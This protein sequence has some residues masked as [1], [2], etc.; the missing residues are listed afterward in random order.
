MKAHVFTKPLTKVVLCFNPKPRHLEHE[1]KKILFQEIRDCICSQGIPLSFSTSIQTKRVSIPNSPFIFE[2]AQDELPKKLEAGNLT[3]LKFQRKTRIYS[4]KTLNLRS[5]WNLSCCFRVC[6]MPGLWNGC[7]VAEIP[8]LHI[9][10]YVLCYRITFLSTARDGFRC[11]AEFGLHIK[12][13][14]INPLSLIGKPEL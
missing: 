11:F 13:K 10:R 7:S 6:L 3:L 14:K 2:G 4:R 8:N 1:K 12:R 5:L 9:F